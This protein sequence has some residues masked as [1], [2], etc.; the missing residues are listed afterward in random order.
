MI[1]ISESEKGEEEIDVRGFF[2][3]GER[4]RRVVSSFFY[5]CGI[6]GASPRLDSPLFQRL[7]CLSKACRSILIFCVTNYAVTPVLALVLL[8]PDVFSVSKHTSSLARSF[9]RYA[10]M[11]SRKQ[12]WKKSYKPSDTLIRTGMHTQHA[13]GNKQGAQQRQK[14]SAGTRSRNIK[15]TVL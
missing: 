4:G 11:Q 7:M 2:S 15:E 5:P 8:T 1:I 10:T 12:M 9:D 6:D 14:R 13:D 3:L